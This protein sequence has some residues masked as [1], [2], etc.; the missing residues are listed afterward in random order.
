MKTILFLIVF[1]TCAIF[2]QTD[3]TITVKKKDLPPDLVKS[4]ETKEQLKDYAEYVGIGKEIG[5][6]LNE[7]LKA[8]VDQAEHFGTTNVGMFTMVMIA[9]S[10]IG[11]DI[12]QIMIGIPIYFIG[13][14]SLFRYYRL[15]YSEH[16]VVTSKSGFF[17]W[18]KKEYKIIAPTRDVDAASIILF[19]F[20]LVWTGICMAIIFA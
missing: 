10:I 11:N 12:I 15:N 1:F 7:G 19:L 5:T 2:A 3:E 20:T 4:L 8:V 9:W 18:A 13:L 16:R 17:L 6:A 14:F